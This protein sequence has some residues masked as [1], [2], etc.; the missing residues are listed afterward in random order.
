MSSKAL[1]LCLL[2][3]A[4]LSAGQVLLWRRQST[5]I[6]SLRRLAATIE[7]RV[8][9]GERPA[10]NYQLEMNGGVSKEDLR[11]IVR[12]ELLALGASRPAVTPPSVAPPETPRRAEPPSGAAADEAFQS[13]RR[14][15]DEALSS[16]VWGERQGWELGRLK[17][18]MAPAQF[19]QLMA[20]LVPAVNRQQ[21]R[22][23]Y[24]G[25]LFG[26]HEMR[27]P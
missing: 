4:T 3:V 20:D 12:E 17:R 1:A 23:D 9:A 13:A 27:G 10:V 2:G 21:V 24:V 8:R 25:P 19:K 14:L 15:V 18:Q 26:A 22:L 7:D 6:E 5:A 16:R 11:L